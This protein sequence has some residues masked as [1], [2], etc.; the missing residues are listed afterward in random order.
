MARTRIKICGIRT[1]EAAR[2]ADEGGSDFV[3]FIIWPGS[4]RYITPEDA[5]AIIEKL[6]HA[7]S[8]GVFVDEP[9]EAV[10]E[11]AERIGLDYVQLHGHEDTGYARKIRRPVIKAWRFGDGF[12]AAE[13]NEFPA[14]IVLL[15]SFVPGQAGG[16]GQPF[17]W[18]EAASETAKLKKPLLVAGGISSGNLEE[19]ARIFHPFGVDVSGSLEENGEKSPKLIRDFLQ[20]AREMEDLP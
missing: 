8:V 9:V 10:N 3:G 18:R 20:I 11:I 7:K 4:R 14:D 16:T 2:A 15:D 12:T 17:A 6:R 19:A 5:A 13:A 1:W